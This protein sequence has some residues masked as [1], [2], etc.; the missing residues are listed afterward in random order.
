MDHSG[1]LKRIQSSVAPERELS[2][3]RNTEGKLHAPMRAVRKEPREHV[4]VGVI[5]S[6][7]AAA[8]EK[9]GVPYEIVDDL[10]DA[11]GGRVN[12]HRDFQKGD[13]FTL[14]YQDKALHNKKEPKAASLLAAMIE[15]GGK[16]IA[17]IRYVGTDGKAR[18]FDQDGKPFE[19][20]F[21]RY[22]AK[23]SYIS[24]PFSQ[25]RFHPVLKYFRPH[26]GV[27]F[28]ATPGTPVRS[29]ANG[30]AEVAGYR[31]ESGI[32]VKIKHSDRYSTAY[33]HLQSVAKGLRQGEHVQRGQVIGYVGCTGLCTGPHLHYSFYDN[34]RYVDPLKINLP[35]ITD[36]KD[37]LRI[38][39]A[40][41]TR[42]LF[43]LRHYQGLPL[44]HSYFG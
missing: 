4:A 43:T 40:Y 29:V 21:L 16:K 28:A 30:E 37:G 41:L 1:R 35:T 26:N 15:A 9:A 27:D 44:G 2:V 22:P 12:F 18:F 17:A 32:M 39:K 7:F 5:H 33:L 13:R 14:I 20:G 11:L 19:D 8:T 25:S 36:L 42:V 24:S 38:Q 3:D 34:G 23:F 6:S 31:G 10:V